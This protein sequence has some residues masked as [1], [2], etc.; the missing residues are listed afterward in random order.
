MTSNVHNL[1]HLVDDVKRYGELDTFSTYPF[2]NMLGQIKRLLRSGK[3]PLVQAAK[4]ISEQSAFEKANV[5]PEASKVILTKKRTA[6]DLP[7]LISLSFTNVKEHRFF[8][9]IEFDDFSLSTDR[10][11]K[12][13][14]TKANEIARLMNIVCDKNI[15]SLFCST[16]AQK[17]DFFETP[18]KSSTLDVYVCDWANAD[19]EDKLLKASDIKCKLVHLEYDDRFDVFIPLMHTK[20]T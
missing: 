14:L 7:P 19:F 8:S 16:T 11:N 10:A 13:F 18:I 12:W 6:H 2:E 3:N 15:V 1:T 20:Y 9:K 5:S 4:R 17:K